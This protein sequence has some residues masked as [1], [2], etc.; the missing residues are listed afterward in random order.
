MFTGRAE[1]RLPHRPTAAPLR[2]EVARTPAERAQGLMHRK[3]LA[4]DAGMLFV[5]PGD[6]TWGFYMR[7]TYVALDMIFVDAAYVVVGVVANV[8]PLTGATRKVDRPSRYVLELRAHRAAELALEPG[9]RLDV[10]WLPD[11]V[12]GVAP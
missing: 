11:A 4:D 6:D 5:M 10:H 2:V 7:N 8:P 9:A 3:T 12:T 1:I